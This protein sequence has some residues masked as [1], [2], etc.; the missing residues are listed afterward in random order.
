MENDADFLLMTA[1]SSETDHLPL[2]PARQHWAPDALARKDEELAEA[3]DYW[4]DQVRSSCERIIERFG[5]AVL[6]A[7]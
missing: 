2:G 1:I 7:G 5:P 4:S 3:A 6:G